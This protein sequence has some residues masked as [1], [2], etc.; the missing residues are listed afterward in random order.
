MRTQ[1]RTWGYDEW[2]ATLVII[3][4][5]AIAG[6]HRLWRLLVHARLYHDVAAV[7]AS[8]ACTQGK[9]SKVLC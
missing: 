3:L 9:T 2:L 4:R 8:L 7:E 6:S 5:L 1:A